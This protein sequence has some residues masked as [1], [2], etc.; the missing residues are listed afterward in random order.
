MR[1]HKF[2]LIDFTAVATASLAVL[3]FALTRNIFSDAPGETQAPEALEWD[4]LLLV[5]GVLAVGLA[6]AIQR[7]LS[8]R[9][10]SVRRMAAEREIRALAFHD[11]LT[12]LPNRRQFDDALKAAA[13]AMP[14]ADACHC[15]IMLDLNGFKRVNDVFGHGT[16]D[17]VLIHVAARLTRAV[18]QGDLVARLGGD[19]FA[20]VATQL[21]GPKR[22]P[23]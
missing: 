2:R 3:Y 17:D 15:I 11:T 21:T 10:E 5:C 4:E 13:A 20:V 7:L 16:G 6:W 18:R 1:R 23:A 12:G 19:E 9:R 22:R 14:G 8:E